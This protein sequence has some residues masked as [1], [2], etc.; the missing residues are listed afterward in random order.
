LHRVFSHWPLPQFTCDPSSRLFA[1]SFKE[2][3]DE[4]NVSTV[5]KYR[6]ELFVGGGKNAVGAIVGSINYLDVFH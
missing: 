3:L 6:F 2:I 4:F 5:A 1:N